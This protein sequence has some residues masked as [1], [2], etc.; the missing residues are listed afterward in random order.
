MSHDTPLARKRK[1]FLS[2]AKVSPVAE[3]LAGIGQG[4]PRNATPAT[5]EA[6]HK[7]SSPIAAESIIVKL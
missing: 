3:T 5:L 6:R 2:K 1:E 4:D 7:R